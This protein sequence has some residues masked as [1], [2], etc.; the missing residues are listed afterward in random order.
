MSTQIYQDVTAMLC[1]VT[2][3]DG[4]FDNSAAYIG[5]WL[6]QLEDDPRLI[7]QA[8]AAAQKAADLV[9]GITY[10]GTPQGE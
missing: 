10:D 1:A 4:V 2:G 8:S 9:R 3:V 5:S 7:V 6:K